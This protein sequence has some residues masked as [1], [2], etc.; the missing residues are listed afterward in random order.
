LQVRDRAEL[1]SWLDHL[2]SCGVTHSGIT[3]MPY[4]S[5]VVFRDPDN[6]QL[7]LFVHPTPEQLAEI[8]G[9]ES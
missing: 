7:E 9:P 2:D 1:Q 3:D 4:G 8:L 6:I 5:V